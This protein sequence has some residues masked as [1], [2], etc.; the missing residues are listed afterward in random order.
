MIDGLVYSADTDSFQSVSKIVEGKHSFERA[1]A[2]AQSEDP[3]FISPS[4]KCYYR[5]QL[6]VM[7]TTTFFEHATPTGEFEIIQPE[8]IEEE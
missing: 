4:Q 1:M 5:S 2:I 7:P 6:W 8:D 3:M